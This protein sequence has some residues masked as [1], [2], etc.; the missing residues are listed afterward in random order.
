MIKF[1]STKQAADVFGVEDRTIR[2]WINE[3]RF[4]N[5][6]KTGEGTAPWLIPAEDVDALRKE[7]ESEDQK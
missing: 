1:Y 5:A 7:P 6:F 4:P 3:G 2:R